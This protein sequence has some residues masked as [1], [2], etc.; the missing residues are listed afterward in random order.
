MRDS[1]KLV[2]ADKVLAIKSQENPFLFSRI[3]EDLVVW[4][5]AIRVA[6]LKGCQRSVS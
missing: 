6:G 1:R 4:N 5:G 3:G 2:K